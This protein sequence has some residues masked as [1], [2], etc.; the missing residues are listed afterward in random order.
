M[1][2]RQ[3]KGHGVCCARKVRLNYMKPDHITKPRTPYSTNEIAA[4]IST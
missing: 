1:A 2:F 4:M 3:W